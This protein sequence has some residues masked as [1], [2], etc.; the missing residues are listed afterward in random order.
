MTNLST[1][2]ALLTSAHTAEAL[3]QLAAWAQTQSPVWRQAA[4]LLQASWAN[5]DRWIGKKCNSL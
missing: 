2:R 4:Q 5:I 1:L 3:T